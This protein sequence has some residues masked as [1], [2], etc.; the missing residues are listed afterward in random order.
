MQKEETIKSLYNLSNILYGL[1][2]Y[3]EYYLSPLTQR[4]ISDIFQGLNNYGITNQNDR[5]EKEIRKIIQNIAEGIK[6]YGVRDVDHG[7]V[8]AAPL[9]FPILTILER[10]N[11]SNLDEEREKILCYLSKIAENVGG[12]IRIISSRSKEETPTYIRAQSIAQNVSLE[13][14]FYSAIYKK[15]W[16]EMFGLLPEKDILALEI[17]ISENNK[18]KRI[19][20]RRIYRKE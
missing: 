6:K 14:E 15:I 1:G 8:I 2:E 5:I 11:I 20:E 3:W 18:N 16:E 13:D 10:L 9:A 4:T 19:L 7:Y 17:E 12:R